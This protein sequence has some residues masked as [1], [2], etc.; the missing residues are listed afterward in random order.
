MIAGHRTYISGPMTGREAYNRP[1]FFA[2][3]TI[4]LAS[5]AASVFNPA[6][7]GIPTA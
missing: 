6:R 7:P 1:A 3:E 2:A 4:L 5:G